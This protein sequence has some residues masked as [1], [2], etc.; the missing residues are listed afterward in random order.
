MFNVLS[1]NYA[2]NIMLA[3]VIPLNSLFGI[4]IYNY[5]IIIMLSIMYLHHDI[6]HNYNYMHSD[7]INQL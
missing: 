4:Y 1:M 2:P 7:G 6:V 3:I 5:N